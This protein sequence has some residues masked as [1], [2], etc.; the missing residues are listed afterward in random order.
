MPA[1][2][3]DHVPVMTRDAMASSRQARDDHMRLSL[4]AVTSRCLLR[5]R[6][7]G[8]AGVTSLL[9][10]PA[11]RLSHRGGGARNVCLEPSTVP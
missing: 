8:S 4:L 2:L 10:P 1:N 3:R 11:S 5:T 7:L 9:D 6:D